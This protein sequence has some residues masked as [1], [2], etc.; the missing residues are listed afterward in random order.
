LAWVK[1]TMNFS[2]TESDK[3]TGYIKSKDQTPIFYRHYS[4]KNPKATV[5]LI[6]GFG[7]HSG[8][9]AHVIESLR[10][11]G[12]EVFCIDFR[13]HGHSRGHRGDVEAFERYEEDVLAALQHIKATQTGKIFVVAHSMGALV[14]L[15][16]AAK[17]GTKIDGMVLSCPLFAL[18]M[19]VPFW[20]K[21]ASIATACL[22]PRVKV[23]TGIK[24][25]HLSTDQRFVAAYDHDP[26][27]LKNLSVRAFYEIYQGCQSSSD[28]GPSI[29]QALFMQVAGSDPVVDSNAAEQ[30]FGTIDTRKVDATLKVYPG[31]L[32]EIYNET[33]R[34]EA[35]SDFI[36]W[37]N[38]H[39]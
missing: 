24:G 4:L 34:D 35:I 8:R 28:L 25:K 22:A 7:E 9:Y 16:L 30:W 27:V 26:L 38:R 36:R 1:G 19:A 15:R 37:L 10:Q 32:H 2:L 12:F 11:A 6:H 20:K 3:K 5:L 39:V 33:Q 13:G 18:K 17:I 14:S 23:S 21:W 29:S 31:F